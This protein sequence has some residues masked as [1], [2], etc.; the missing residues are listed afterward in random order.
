[1]E[2]WCCSK[3]TLQHLEGLVRR[4]LLY[5][6]TATEEWQLSSEENVPSSPDGYIVSFMCF[7]EHRFTTPTHRFL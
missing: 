4:G 3:I 5:V 2:P 1:M 6:W 7:H